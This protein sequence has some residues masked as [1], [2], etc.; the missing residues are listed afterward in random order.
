[1]NKTFRYIIVLAAVIVGSTSASA[2]LRGSD[3]IIVT[4]VTGGTV[5][6]KYQVGEEEPIAVTP[7]TTDVPAGATVTVGLTADVVHTLAGATVTAVTASPTDNA[8]VRSFTRSGSDGPGIGGS[9]I[10]VSDID[11]AGNCTFTMPTGSDVAFTVRFADKPFENVA[12]INAA[13]ILCDGQGDHPAKVKAYVLDGSETVLGVSTSTTWYVVPDNGISYSQALTLAG[14]TNIIVKDGKTLTTPGISGAHALSIFG[15]SSATGKV[16]V[17]ERG[18]DIGSNPLVLA[19]VDVSSI[20]KSGDDHYGLIAS[21]IDI[22]GTTD[23]K[24][25]LYVEAENSAILASGNVSISGVSLSLNPGEG[26]QI[27]ANG[28]TITLG[29][30]HT[31]DYFNIGSYYGT[32][33]IAEGQYFQNVDGN[34]RI[35]FSGTP[36][37]EDIVSIGLTPAIPITADCITLSTDPIVYNGQVQ[38][39]DVTVT[40]GDETLT[41]N[42]DFTLGYENAVDAGTD[43]FVTVTPKGLYFGIDGSTIDTEL[44]M[45]FTISPKPVGIS[46]GTDALIYDG[47]E[48]APTASTTG[49]EDVD[50]GKVSVTVS[51]DG[52]HSDAGDYTATVSAL[53]GNR[54]S[55][56]RLP[57]SSEAGYATLTNAFAISPKPVTVSGTDVTADNKI[58]DG[59]TSATLS[60]SFAFDDDMIID[61]DNVTITGGTGAFADKNVGTSKTVTISGIALSGTD[62]GNYTLSAQPTGVTGNIAKKTVTVTGGITANN[63]TYDGKTTATLSGSG[64]TISGKVTGDKLSVSATGAFADKDAGNN[65]TVNINS[66]TLTGSDKDN[67]TLA[68]TGSNQATTTATIRKKALTVTADDKSVSYGDAAPT[69]TASYS[70]FVSGESKSNLSGSLKFSCSY[71]SSSTTG[72]YSITPSGLSSS[73]Y[74]ISYTNGTLTVG[75]STVENNN[76]TTI[77]QDE[78]GYSVTVGEGNGSGGVI[79]IPGGGSSMDVASLEYSRTLTAPT[80]SNK[81]VTIGGKAAKLYTTCMP[82]APATNA[83]VKYYTLASVSGTT[84]NFNEV[85]SP[86]ADT[87]YLMAVMGS[88]AAAESVTA[89]NVTLKKMVTGSSANG[90]TMMGTQTGLDN[91]GAVSAANS[92]DVTYILQDQDKWGKVVSGT[93]Y[94]PPFRA[95]I[96]GPALS[97]NARELGSSFD[98]DATGIVSLRLLDAD[99]TEQWYDLSGRRISKPTRKG[100]YIHNGKVTTTK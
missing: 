97:A 49:V 79:V 98:D 94:I 17:T 56:Y 28:H 11:E 22:V 43:N 53:S 91:G 42:T 100:L 31:D 5:A 40:C 48:K 29:W 64:A 33:A 7:G 77:T 18:I 58:Y 76:G 9:E 12:Y 32:L 86:A 85:T 81:D 1:M 60:G 25:S 14:I 36:N 87:P 95:F 62:A 78:N 19:N 13:G 51:V 71:T 70:G 15:Q 41:E 92:G 68:T 50:A 35:I 61:G 45:T 21:T 27:S 26:A 44:G 65:K 90:F 47:T 88:T 55:N 10:S 59:T 89:Q 67:Y 34:R 39:P 57:T 3:G 93:V 84:L 99:G 83:N 30:T 80:E 63:K 46:W 75:A 20:G 54:A 38:L 72:T 24:N 37:E 96:V 82:T 2:R 74:S 16:N 73:N 52:D 8:Q 66:I 69:Y 4:D 6:I 23:V